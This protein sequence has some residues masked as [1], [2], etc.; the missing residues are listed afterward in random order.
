[1]KR[2]KKSATEDW[3]IDIFVWVAL[4]LVFLITAYP[5]YYIVIASFNDGYDF[6]RG[7]IYFF[8]REF[9]WSNYTSLLGQEKWMDA[10]KISFIRTIV[11]TALTVF[12]TCLVSY[13]LSRKELMFGKVY[14]FMVVFSMYVSGGLIPFLYRIKESSFT[15]YD[16]GIYIS[17]HA[18]SFFYYCGHQFFCCN[19][20]FSC[21]VCKVGRCIGV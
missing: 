12:V 16:M 14:R 20:Q 10:F 13:S 9:T 7:G 2:K 15:Q 5:F 19:S 4:I 17:I 21:G 6:M 11:G 1:M 8:P 18:E 3:L